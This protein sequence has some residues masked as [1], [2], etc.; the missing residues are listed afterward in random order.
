MN[1]QEILG[2]FFKLWNIT[3]LFGLLLKFTAFYRI[4]GCLRGLLMGQS[5]VI[6]IVIR[7]E[8]GFTGQGMALCD[9][10]MPLEGSHPRKY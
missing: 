3:G 6:L 1:L 10:N 2:V 9:D 7:P 4:T 8:R 5:S